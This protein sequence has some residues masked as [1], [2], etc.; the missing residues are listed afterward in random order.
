MNSRLKGLAW[1][2]LFTVTCGAG[3]MMFGQNPNVMPACGNIAPKAFYEN[4]TTHAESVRELKLA[5]DLVPGS[6]REQLNY[7]LALLRAGDLEAAVALLEKVQ[8]ADPKLPHTWFN[9]GI[10]FKKQNE[11][12][13][14]LA[15]FQEFVRLAPKEPVAHYQ[16]GAVYKLKDDTAQA[17]AQFEAARD[18]QPLLAAPHFQLFGLYRQ[19]G[20]TEQAA[21]ELRVF[22]ALKKQ[23]EGAAIPE[24][25]DWC[26]YGELYDP[27]DAPPSAPLAP[28]KYREE[29]IA[30]GF[31]GGSSGVAA[32][33]GGSGRPDLIAWSNHRVAVFR[34]GR[35]L[36]AD[37]GLEQLRDVR[38]IAPGDF[39]NDGLV[40]LCVI[41]GKGAMLYRNTGTK[42]VKHSDL[43]TG[44][45]RKAVWLDFDHD[46]DEDIFL[47]GDDQR[48]MRN[49]G[50]AGF[51]DESKRFP[52][53]EGHAI[54]AVPFDLEPD[55]PGFDLVASYVG[56]AG[57]LYFQRWA[58]RRSR[59]LFPRLPRARL[60]YRR[61]ISITMALP[62]WSLR[63]PDGW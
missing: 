31:G 59:C 55:T 48:L 34:N 2:V 43:A 20:L 51:S 44:S 56:H 29:K 5:L 38:F 9:L 28:A 41:T 37:T 27:I 35:T 13:R 54:D 15:Q 16:L 12:D 63:R 14:A 49:N 22:Q 11:A 39:D 52:F 23:S 46:Y 57:V 26:Q 32:L 8:K 47:L 58:A 60:G 45:F 40:D 24:D 3:W 61:S 6:V 17:I 10:V 30:D 42:F 36:I 21:A 7:G 1:A 25:M 62:T 19:A 53:A 18:L 4:P 33:V 50:D